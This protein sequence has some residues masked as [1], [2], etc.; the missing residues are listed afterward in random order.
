MKV[1][2]EQGTLQGLQYNTKLSYKPY[3]SFLGI[4]YA[5]PPIDDLRFKVKSEINTL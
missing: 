4:P 3:V 2:I 5:K 1:T